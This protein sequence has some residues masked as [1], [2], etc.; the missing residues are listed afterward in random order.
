MS[1]AQKKREDSDVYL[2]FR[3]RRFPPTVP[4]GVR[5]G[6]EGVYHSKIQKPLPVSLGQGNAINVGELRV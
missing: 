2:F 1:S 4:A 5:G 3:Q 6:E